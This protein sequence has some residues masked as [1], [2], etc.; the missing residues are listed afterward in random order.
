MRD[1]FGGAFMIKLFLVFILVYVSFTAI[2]LNYAKAFKVKNEVIKYIESNEETPFVNP[3]AA[4]SKEI[5]TDI[6]QIAQQLNYHKDIN[7]NVSNVYCDSGIRIE[8]AGDATNTNGTYYKVTTTLGWSI[9]FLNLFKKASGRDDNK[10]VIG[11]WNISGE[12]RLIVNDDE[13]K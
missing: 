13:T 1:A 6:Q 9:N 3:N 4:E 7:C 2:A 5:K 10:N 11:T 8:E 12:T